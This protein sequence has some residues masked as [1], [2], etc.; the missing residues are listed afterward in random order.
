VRGPAVRI[1]TSTPRR[2]AA[3]SRSVKLR[4]G[5]K[6]EFGMY[7]FLRA[8]AIESA[9]RRSPAVRA[10][11]GAVYRRPAAVAPFGSDVSGRTRQN[12]RRQMAADIAVR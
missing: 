10:S 1:R 11:V 9:K 2:A 12:G 5:A 3:E 7:S 6:Y 4:S 8:P